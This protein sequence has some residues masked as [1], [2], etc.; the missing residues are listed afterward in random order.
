MVDTVANFEPLTPTAFL[1]RSACVF[2]DRT[3]VVDGDRRFTYAEF[4]DR[5]LPSARRPAA[6]LGVEP[7]DRVAV[8]APQHAR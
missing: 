4:H 1:D 5:C 2:A 3:A 6:G 7:G 8:L